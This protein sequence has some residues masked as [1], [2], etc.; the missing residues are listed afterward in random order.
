M[1]T[2]RLSLPVGRGVESG[3]PVG[4]QLIGR[5]FSEAELPSLL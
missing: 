1:T 5:A 2:Q 3:M 4:M